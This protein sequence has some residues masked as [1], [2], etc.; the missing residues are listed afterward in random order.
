[1]TTF[2]SEG[3]PR[4]SVDEAL[5]G[6][7][8]D[9]RDARDTFADRWLNDRGLLVNDDVLAVAR[10]A[11]AA[12]FTK[13]TSDPSVS[14]L[15]REVVDMTLDLVGG[16]PEAV[17]SMTSGGTESLFVATKAAYTHAA[18]AGRLGTQPEILL[19]ASGYASFEKIASYLPC[20]V[21]RVPLAADLTADID[22]L[23]AA[24]TPNTFMLVGSFPDWSFGTCDPIAAMGRLTQERE[25][26]LHVDACVGGFV[27]PFLRLL[28]EPV[29]D[30]GL[31]VPGV[32]SVSADIHKYGYGPK[33]AS[34][35]LFSSAL[36]RVGHVFE[37]DAWPAGYYRSPGI[38]G[39]RAAGAVAAA[40][41]VM[42][43][44]GADGYLRLTQQILKCKRRILAALDEQGLRVLGRADLA[45][46]SFTADDVDILAVGEAVVDAGWSIGLLA[47]PPGIQLVLGPFRDE[48][49]TAL[50]ADLS[51]A[52]AAV[53][54]AAAPKHRRRR[55][56]YSDEM[57]ADEMR[58]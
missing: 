38:T 31:S 44:L 46:V 8:R 50:L 47:T 41:A 49:V 1:M 40:W 39:T 4:R 12:F 10:A 16:G 11:Y 57:A 28:G 29:A 48:V 54:H 19:T 23:R 17:G 5:V 20:T 35:I 18:R 36:A 15:E 26:W 2:P 58:T 22:A 30:F 52:L 42:R 43:Y 7:R 45:T 56:V 21:V 13:N 6:E 33:G 24:V 32:S 9:M 51:G 55:V 37:F 53:R 34:T 27:A 3:I 14:G 25:L